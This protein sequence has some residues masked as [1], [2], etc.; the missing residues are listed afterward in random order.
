MV[1]VT[2]QARAALTTSRLDLE[3]LRVEHAEEMAPL[4]DDPVLHTYIGGTPATLSQ[5]RERYRRMVVGRSP[6]GSQRWLNW[7]LRRRVDGR[8]VGTLQATLYE[9]TP[10]QQ[11]VIA[12]VAWVVAAPYQ[13]RGYAREAAQTMLT[14]LREQDVTTVVAHVHPEHAASRGVAR[15]IGLTET[16]TV[17]DGETRWHRSLVQGSRSA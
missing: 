10:D 12:E 6:D 13:G 11:G 7:V 16:T 1:S 5:L 2:S 8:A 15:A 9:G 14:W 17:V 3:L 4:L